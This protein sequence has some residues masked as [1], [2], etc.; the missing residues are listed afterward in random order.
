M[1]VTDLAWAA[2][3][4]DGEGC[5]HISRVKASVCNQRQ[6]D[7]Y[8]LMLK[9]TMTH[10]ETIDKF[11]TILPGATIQTGQR[12]NRKRTYTLNY[13]ITKAIAAIRLLLPYLVTKKKEAKLALR[14]GN[15]PAWPSRSGKR[16][17]SLTQLR[18]TYY[19]LMRRYK[20][21]S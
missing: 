6:S 17:A 5:I 21:E 19:L 10:K 7:R 1:R 16:P 11:Y 2:G 15:V 20:H 18:H 12:P 8:S 14:Y 9:L 4:I 3:I 13:R